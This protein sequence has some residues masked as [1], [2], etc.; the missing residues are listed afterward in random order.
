V[1]RRR[2]GNTLE[3]WEIA[4]I[5]ALLA[6]GGYNDQD[7]LAFFTRPTRSINHRAIGEIRTETKHRAIRA[8]S[9]EELDSFLPH[10]QT[11]ARRLA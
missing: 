5:K 2:P 10:G 1:P 9:T 7:V 6:Q 3:R 4:L 11:S 8:A